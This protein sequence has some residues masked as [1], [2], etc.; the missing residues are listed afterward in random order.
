MGE[1]LIVDGSGFFFRAFHAVPE[2]TSPEGL[3]VNAVRGFVTMALRPILERSSAR[4]AV[5]VFDAPGPTFREALFP[6]YKAHRPP[7]PEALTAQAPLVREA[8]LAFGFSI[9]DVPGFEADDVIATVTSMALAAGDSAIV[10]SSDKDLMQL[11]R[12]GVRMYDQQRRR[13]IG[14]SEVMEKFGVSPDLVVDV[15]ALA[16]DA[17]DG[18]PGVAGIGLKTAAALIS[19]YG[20]LEG[21]LA[22]AGAVRQP[23]RRKAL[24]ESVGDARLSYVLA[25][26][27]DDVPLPTPYSS[28]ERSM[29][30]AGRIRAFLERMGFPPRLAPS[31][32]RLFPASFIPSSSFPTLADDRLEEAE[33]LS[34]ASASSSPPDWEEAPLPEH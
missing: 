9:L 24:L 10:V 7:H 29:P 11:V 4:S 23:A 31:A 14:P 8:A 15:Q 17:A 16:G 22:N 2:E 3:P 21:L 1:I 20:S 26:L 18:I 25:R 5:V 28:F 13:M 27:R 33:E 34:E 12:P 32:S 6:A 19:E 30:D